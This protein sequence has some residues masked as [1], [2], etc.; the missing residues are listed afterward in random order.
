MSELSALDPNWGLAGNAGGVAPGEL[1]IR[2]ADPHGSDQN[3]HSFPVPVCSLD[4]NFIVLRADARLAFSADLDGFH[5]YGTDICLLADVHGYRSYVID[6]HLR[7][8]SAGNKSASFHDCEAA[9][10]E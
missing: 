8:L 7:H 4:E 5:F 3:T 6:F 1:A 2:I 10:A 9:L